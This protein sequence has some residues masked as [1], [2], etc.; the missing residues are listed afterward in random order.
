MKRIVLVIVVVAALCI[1]SVPA[2]AANDANAVL[3]SGG[4]V[5]LH[6][7]M[8]LTG[9]IEITKDT[10]LDLN[11][12]TITGK[13][14]KTPFVNGDGKTIYNADCYSITVAQGVCFSVK[15]GTIDAAR[16]DNYGTID[17]IKN[18]TFNA[19]D[20][21][22]AIYNCGTIQSISYCTIRGNNQGIS[23]E[24]DINLIDNCDIE[25]KTTTAIGNHMYVSNTDRDG[26]NTIA[27]I[28]HCR[29]V[30]TDELR[31]TG[32]AG[33]EPCN[34]ATEIYDSVLI[35][36]GRGGMHVYGQNPVSI[37]DSII[38]CTNDSE[39]KGLSHPAAIWEARYGDYPTYTAP[40][41][42]NCTLIAMDGPCGYYDSRDVEVGKGDNTRFIKE[43][44][45]VE[46]SNMKDSDFIRLNGSNWEKYDDWSM[47]EEPIS[48]VSTGFTNFVNVNSYTQGRFSDVKPTDWFNAN[49][50]RA[51]ELGLMKGSS[52][53]SFAPTGKVT[54]AEAVAMASRLHSIYATGAESFI[55]GN[56]W[57][58]T[59]VDYAKSNGIISDD[60]ENYNAAATRSQFAAIFAASMPEDAFAEINSISD[61]A[62]PDVK[63]N[64]ASAD[65]IYT[66]YRAGILSGSDAKGAFLPASSISRAEAA[67]I[68]TR[69][70]DISLRKQ[71]TLE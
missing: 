56:V 13:A 63:S 68:I 26:K 24:G 69:M 53:D 34:G 40:Y 46:Y 35:G 23:N 43:W 61:N 2:F 1:L 36:Y 62:I 7:N 49:V 21:D 3:T 50:A 30:C 19:G 51:Y 59:Y 29:I 41:V 18:V 17:H 54:L 48:V 33:G 38:I 57:Y 55:Q 45:Y 5:S 71:V 4:N 14:F 16:I 15:N 42:E 27:K 12:H 9:G 6:E 66:L 22:R 20:A 39:E 64:A 37:Y 52:S 11:G 70:A 8:T 44:F 65:A 25:T 60:F 47:D 28:N 31:G 67:A 32:F 10:V 58:Q